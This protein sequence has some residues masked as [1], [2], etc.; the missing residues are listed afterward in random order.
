VAWLFSFYVTPVI[1]KLPDILDW[2]GY[3]YLRFIFCQP[4]G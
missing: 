4:A 1:R 3:C 2:P